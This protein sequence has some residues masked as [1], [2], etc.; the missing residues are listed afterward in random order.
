MLVF[1]RLI[2]SAGPLARQSHQI[3]VLKS[4]TVRFFLITSLPFDL[5]DGA[6]A[7]LDVSAPRGLPSS[8]FV[9]LGCPSFSFSSLFCL[10]SVHLC[11]VFVLLVVGFSESQ[12]CL[13]PSSYPSVH[14][15]GLPLQCILLYYVLFSLLFCPLP[16]LF[17]S[18]LFVLLLFLAAFLVPF[19][20]TAG[21]PFPCCFPG[22]FL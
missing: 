16:N 14:L 2:V 7:R 21:R 10:G 20:R 12:L 11:F 4:S 22:L 9:P 3:R 1:D 6:L 17:V 18:F 19:F 5:P 13:C 15:L 8:F